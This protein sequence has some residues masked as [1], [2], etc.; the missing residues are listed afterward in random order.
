M[1]KIIGFNILLVFM[2]LIVSCTQT[3]TT[4]F[5]VTYETFGGTEIEEIE[6]N[7]GDSIPF[8]GLPTKDGF[9]FLGWYLEETFETEVDFNQIVEEDI[10]I[11]AKWRDLSIVQV[12][13]ITYVL[14]EGENSSANPETFTRNDL[15]LTL[16]DATL[17]GKHFVGWKVNG[18]II[19]TIPNLSN[20]DKDL[21]LE[22]VFEDIYTV[23]YYGFGSELVSNPT[24]YYP[25]SGTIEL[26]VPEVAGYNFLGWALHGE[27]VK[28]IPSDSTGNLNLKTVFE[29]IEYEVTYDLDGGTNSKSNPDKYTRENETIKLKDPTKDGYIFIGWELDGKIITE[30]ST[31]IVKN[32][33]LKAVWE[34]AP[35]YHDITFFLNGGTVTSDYDTKYQEGVGMVLPTIK[36]DGYT[37][38][39]WN[40]ENKVTTNYIKEI[41]ATATTDYTLYAIF[42]K[43]KVY[44]SINY[45]LYD[46]EFEVEAPTKYEEGQTLD[47]PTPVKAGYEFAGWYLNKEFSGNEITYI[48]D[49]NTGDITLHAKWVS[50]IP[51]YTVTYNLNGGTFKKDTPY[52]TRT[53]MV[54]DFLKDINAYYKVSMTVES[55]FDDSYNVSALSNF[56]NNA[57]YKEK[58][59]WVKE[60][61]IACATDTG[62]SGLMYLTDES[63]A[64][65][66]TYIRANISSFL[67]ESYR[68][69]WPASMDFTDDGLA[70]GYVNYLPG[71][72]QNI[73][74]EFTA[75]TETFDLPIV[76]RNEFTFIG[77]FNEQGEKVEQIV[78]GTTGNIVL[79][80]K[81]ESIYDIYTITY[82]TNGGTLSAD[83]VFEF[84]ENDLIILKPAQKEGY[85]FM[86]WYGDSMFETTIITDIPEG[87]KENITLYARY[88]VKDYSIKF[89]TDGGTHTNTTTYNI[90][91]EDIILE[92]AQKQGYRFIGWYDASG[93]KVTMIK[94]GTYGNIELTAKYE[95]TVDE[96]IQYTVTF[97]NEL[98]EV[99]RTEKVS[100]GAC[101]SEILLGTYEGLQLAWFDGGK[102]Y[103]FET[104]LVGDVTLYARWR[105]ID[106]IYNTIFYD[107]TLRDNVK[108]AREFDTDMGLISIVWRTSNGYAINTATGQVSPD[109]DEQL[110]DITG[111]FKLNGKSF[112][113]IREYKVEKLNF[114]DLS[115]GDKPVFGYLYSNVAS[116]E[117]PEVVLETVDVLNYSFARVTSTGVVDATELRHITKV[118]ELRKKGIRVILTIGGYGTACKEFSDAAYTQEGREKLAASIVQCVKD[119]HFDGVDIDWEYPG[120]QTGRDTSIDRPNFTLLMQEIR[121]QLK[122]ANPEYL[123]TA[124]IPGGKYGYTR[125]E[126]SKLNSILDYFHLMTYDLQASD[127]ATHHTGL[128]TGS[129]TPHGS[130]EQTV[131]LFM[132]QGVSKDKLVVGLAFYGRKFNVTSSGT[133]IG[134]DNNVS[135]ADAITYTNIYNNYLIPIKNG[136]TTITRYWDDK[137]KAPYIYDKQTRIWITYDDPESITYK[138]EYV[139]E[140]GLAGVMFWDY[141]E[142]QTFQLTQ[143]IHDTLRK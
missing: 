59:A 110:V 25:S 48:K 13:T 27:V 34:V 65:H 142:D 46:G 141:G 12:N 37:F 135:S 42:E 132:A 128:Y 60:Y 20:Y 72:E 30:I 88:K 24:E 5:K 39:G 89:N 78:K 33:T 140:K 54:N 67:G 101:A 97:I 119:N 50:N 85:Y 7:E 118:A 35:V 121:R 3:T 49:T 126:L 10:T 31:D 96:T 139:L 32:I 64:Y 125:Y 8:P 120:Y 63:D 28:Y 98:D 109:Y 94:Q 22:A 129:Y 143:A 69:S 9:E 92:D 79:N 11:Y 75:D 77:W 134:V 93:E 87:T 41:P 131:N 52:A 18:A 71:D 95:V 51:T 105:V 90:E 102:L 116:M 82:I 83:T 58:W 66:N 61:I 23:L 29:Y 73:V 127:R 114:R 100:H 1:K 21:T 107:Y 117:T 123:V 43:I 70:N 122:E 47:L 38:L 19:K 115:T 80:A 74:Y 76:T 130:V 106:D 138:C 44:S 111:T 103:D 15:P 108:I 113:I 2:L 4:S 17:E 104:K 55:F 136:S 99:V 40:T 124:A 62:Y 56:F 36:K 86:G 53:E 137:T 57:S 68:S 133:G 45:E 16:S 26:A 91:S 112:T 14:N 6:V 81:F 84:T